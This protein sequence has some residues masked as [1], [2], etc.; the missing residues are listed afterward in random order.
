LESEEMEA[1]AESKR[2]LALLAAKASVM[3]MAMDTFMMIS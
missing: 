2:A 1:L 3:M